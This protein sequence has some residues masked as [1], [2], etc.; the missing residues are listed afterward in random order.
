MGHVRAHGVGVDEK[1]A[2]VDVVCGTISRKYEPVTDPAL[3]LHGSGLSFNVPTSARAAVRGTGRHRR[4]HERPSCDR[5]EAGEPMR[6][7][8]T[9]SLPTI[10]LRAPVAHGAR[11]RD[12][13]MAGYTVAAGLLDRIPRTGQPVAR[14][15]DRRTRP[16]PANMG[17]IT[18]DDNGS[19]P[20][21]DDRPDGDAGSGFERWRQES[22]LGAV[23]TGI[24]KGLRNVFAP[25]DDHQVI[26][27]EVPGDPPGADER[28]RVVLDP[29][30]PTK[31][32]A[33]VPRPAEPD[34]GSPPEPGPEETDPVG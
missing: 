17:C 27:A 21:D 29:D 22:A 23:G 13:R 18:Q 33:F 8:R 9:T 3:G 19:P 7:K 11:T 30:D 2:G 5:N 26:V 6:V 20:E 24:A 12:E 31:A 4:E 10:P 1:F 15:S 32:V 28:L 25:T 34:D 14:A 16:D